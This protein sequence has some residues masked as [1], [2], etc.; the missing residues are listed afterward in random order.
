MIRKT[1]RGTEMFAADS[2]SISSALINLQNLGATITFFSVNNKDRVRISVN[3][4]VAVSDNFHVC[5]SLLFLAMSEKEKISRY[6]NAARKNSTFSSAE[7]SKLGACIVCGERK[8]IFLLFHKKNAVLCTHCGNLLVA[9]PFLGETHFAY[10]YDT[11]A[12]DAE[13]VKEVLGNV[14][15]ANLEAEICSRLDRALSRVNGKL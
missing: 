7:E 14:V 10:T 8:Y 6:R 5:T 4:L 2:E 9:I 11:E 1:L 12:M 15:K 3:G 13:L